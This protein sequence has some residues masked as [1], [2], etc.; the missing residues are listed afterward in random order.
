[1][2][3]LYTK[4]HCAYCDV[5]KNEADK[6]GLTLELRDV[7]DEGI[8]DELVARGGKKQVPY[9]V[10]DETGSEMYGSDDIVQYLHERFKRN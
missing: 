7:Y 1:M 5:V 8:L 2:L 3:I 9:F 10:D 4:P 6:L